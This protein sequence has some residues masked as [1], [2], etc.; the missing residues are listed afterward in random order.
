MAELRRATH[1]AE[2]SMSITQI[3]EH[4][5]RSN[6]RTCVQLR[7]DLVHGEGFDEDS[8]ERSRFG[9]RLLR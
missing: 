1:G 2:E 3:M 9:E 6:I 7:F 4:G 8:S 5:A